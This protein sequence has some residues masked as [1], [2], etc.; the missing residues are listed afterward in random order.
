MQK[1]SLQ[2]LTLKDYRNFSNLGLE[3]QDKVVV[4]IGPNGSGKTNILESISLLSPGRGLRSAKFDEII[5]TGQQSWHSSFK[6][7]SKL[8]AS[9]ISTDFLPSGTRTIEY[10]GSRIASNEL[11]GLI[12]MV[13][14]TPQMEGIFTGSSSDRRRFL[15]RIVYSF[16]SLHAKRIN[17]YDYY[18]RQR[19][20]V[21]TQHDKSESDIWLAG[22]EE[23]MASVA[24]DIDQ[25]RREILVFMQSSIDGLDTQ[26]PKAKLEVSDLLENTDDNIDFT[27]Y[28]KNKLKENRRKDEFSGRT[29]FGVHKTDFIV[30]HREKKQL[31]KYCSTGEQKAMLISIILAQIDSLKKNAKILPVVLLD[32]L[33][34]HLDEKRREYLSD[35]I[36]NSNIQTFIT[37]TEISGQITLTS[38]AQLIEVSK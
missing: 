17:K 27:E 16:D 13:W 28:C 5:K 1:I 20:K 14:L 24:H 11:S 35:Y 37:A 31:A 12:S 38:D 30:S 15:D 10:N 32:E 33:F 9:Q 25:K 19:L 36:F 7:Q 8:G 6:L 29:N 21:L 18:M 23:A 2:T 4:I 3:F 34:V 26:F 22:L